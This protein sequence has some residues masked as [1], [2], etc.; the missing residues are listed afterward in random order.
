MEKE[1][2]MNPLRKKQVIYPSPVP[3]MNP[4][5]K[6]KKMNTSDGELLTG[7]SLRR[8]RIKLN[9]LAKAAGGGENFFERASRNQNA[10]N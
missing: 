5:K 3:F 10:K 1:I 4:D 7:K 6:I 8:Y 2:E 9:R